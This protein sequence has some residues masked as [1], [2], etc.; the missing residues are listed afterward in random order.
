MHRNESRLLKVFHNMY[1]PMDLILWII[2]KEVVLLKL[3]LKCQLI[4]SLKLGKLD[5]TCVKV[6]L[7]PPVEVRVFL[8]ST[9][10]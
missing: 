10:I 3:V 6:A 9:T 7:R 8:A 1:R 5:G 4:V 2:V